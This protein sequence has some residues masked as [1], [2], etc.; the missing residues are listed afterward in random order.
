MDDDGLYF[1]IIVF[2]LPFDCVLS[3][4]LYRLSIFLD[5]PA[6]NDSEWAYEVIDIVGHSGGG[7]I[8]N[9]NKKGII[10]YL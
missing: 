6:F 1:S 9:P 8:V 5:W 3:S 7:M 2:G 10:F 4:D